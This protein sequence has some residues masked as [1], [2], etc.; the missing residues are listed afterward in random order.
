MRNEENICQKLQVSF[1]ASSYLYK[2]KLYLYSKHTADLHFL[3]FIQ[4]FC[5]LLICSVIGLFNRFVFEHSVFFRVS[6]MPKY[7]ITFENTNLKSCWFHCADLFCTEFRFCETFTAINSKTRILL[8]K[9]LY[10]F[11]NI[12]CWSTIYLHISVLG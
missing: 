6:D 1:L 9:T 8:I 7:S 3:T 5:A 4:I 11:R 2:Y 10:K 12:K